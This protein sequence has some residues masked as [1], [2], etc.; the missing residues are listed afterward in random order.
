MEIPEPLVGIW[1]NVSVQCFSNYCPNIKLKG[2]STD[3]G[4]D[5]NG[6][7]DLTIDSVDW[8][9]GRP[10]Y[11]HSNMDSHIFWEDYQWNIGVLKK[12]N[13]SIL[14]DLRIKSKDI[15]FPQN[16]IPIIL[17]YTW[18]INYFYTHFTSLSFR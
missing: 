13:N 11:K 10:V 9:P 18:R 14:T 3:S 16:Q 15:I 8:A 12:L 1:N 17:F 2:V 4:I 6:K 7:Y 5:F